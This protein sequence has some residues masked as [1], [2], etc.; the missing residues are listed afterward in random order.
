MIKVIR[1]KHWK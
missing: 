1:L